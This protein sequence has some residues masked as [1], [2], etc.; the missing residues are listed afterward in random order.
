[1]GR[2]SQS[3]LYISTSRKFAMPTMFLELLYNIAVLISNRI[4]SKIVDGYNII[5]KWPRLG[6]H[7]R[8]N[9]PARARQLL[10]DDLENLRSL[11]GWRIE[12]V[13]DG[14]GKDNRVGPLG[15]SGQRRLSAADKGTSKDVS[16]HGVR[17]V[18]TGT[19]I[20]ADSYIESRCQQAK[21]VTRGELTGSLI[22]ATDDAMIRLAGQNAGAMCM[23][24]DRFV[25]ELKAMKK[26]VAYRVEAAMAKV[27]GE[28]MRPEKLWGSS[29]FAR[30]PR[31]TQSLN[32]TANPVSPSSIKGISGVQQT[33]D[34]KTIYTGRFG[35]NAL[36]IEDRRKKKS[37][38][39]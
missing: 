22:V 33:E 18:F 11:K 25:L 21:N 39:K 12:V 14:A 36:I 27:N 17:V 6:K 7:M 13:F 1:M 3:N 28:R 8:K 26:A 20:E 23:G 19:G 30:S 35:G 2:H 34:G 10:V 29:T 38:K 9:D 37:N 31:P 16:K 24:A 4:Y 32:S 5:Y 15:E